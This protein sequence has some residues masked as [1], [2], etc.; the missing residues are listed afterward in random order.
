MIS[1][2]PIEFHL[3][4]VSSTNDYAKELL[5]RYNYVFVSAMHQ[6]AGRGRNGKAWFGDFGVNAYCSLGVR[7]TSEKSVSDLAAYMA[8][9][10]LA[11]IYTLREC[12]PDKKFRLKY[13]NDV[14]VM[15]ENGWAKIAG[16]LVEHEFLGSTCTSSVIGVGI[17]NGQRFFPDTINRP[18][19]SLR[20]VGCDIDVSKLVRQLKTDLVQTNSMQTDEALQCW[21]DELD[22]LGASIRILDDSSEW[23]VTKVM[24]DGRLVAKNKVS[25]IERTVTDGDSVRY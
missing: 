14:Q 2:Q 13:P 9:G 1:E 4:S 24:N 17:N 20:L 3:P 22:I 21:V 6:T 5:R 12:S 7:H 10:A 11:A 15:M 18:C 8:K 23:V 25:L 16:I 19:T